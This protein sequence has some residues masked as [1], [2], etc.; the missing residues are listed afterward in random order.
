[1]CEN[2]SV[3]YSQHAA[4][5]AAVL[6]AEGLPAM[7]L[8]VTLLPEQQ[9]GAEPRGADTARGLIP[10]RFGFAFLLATA[11][12]SLTSTWANTSGKHSRPL[13]NRSSRQSLG[14]FH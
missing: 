10:L 5:G 4:A 12:G 1:M 6:Q 14:C 3:R 2:T 13:F 11:T 9:S 8:S 7:C